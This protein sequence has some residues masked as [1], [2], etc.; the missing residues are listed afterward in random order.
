MFREKEERGVTLEEL[1]LEA[2]RQ[3]KRLPLGGVT[4]EVEDH[5]PGRRRT[6]VPARKGDGGAGYGNTI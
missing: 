3:L 1:V 2:D 4:I 5:M 6:R